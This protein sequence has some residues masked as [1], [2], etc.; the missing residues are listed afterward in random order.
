MAQKPIACGIASYYDTGHRTASGDYFNPSGMTAAHKTLPY[1]TKVK[2]T[3]QANGKSV[4]VTIN[5]RGPYVK[6][7]I[8]DLAAGAAKK[9][10]ITYN[11]GIEKVCIYK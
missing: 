2:V 10:G 7:R 9:I 1:G 11:N 4:T 5:D 3:N 6:G 8:I